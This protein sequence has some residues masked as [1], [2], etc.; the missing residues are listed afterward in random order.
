[1]GPAG[2]SLLSTQER[3]DPSNLKPGLGTIK[4]GHNYNFTHSFIQPHVRPCT[5]GILGDSILESCNKR[6]SAGQLT[7]AFQKPKLSS[8]FQREK[9][10]MP[11]KT[12]K[13]ICT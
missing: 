5:A 13:C 4:I 10:H 3:K 8:F 11:A 7:V 6:I 12:H 2:K 1:L 9:R